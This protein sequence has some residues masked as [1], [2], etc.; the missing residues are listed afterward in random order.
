MKRTRFKSI[1][2][3]KVFFTIFIIISVVLNAGLFLLFKYQKNAFKYKLIRSERRLINS[4]SLNENYRSMILNNL[5]SESSP[6]NPDLVLTNVITNTKTSIREITKNSPILIL[7]FTEYSCH[8]CIE[9]SFMIIN[10]IPHL[11]RAEKFIIIVS[12]E[13]LRDLLLFKSDNN[14]NYSIYTMR[15]DS[16]T[17]PLESLNFPY[18]FILDTEN[19]A[20][21]IFYPLTSIPELTE[22]YFSIIRYKY[23]TIFK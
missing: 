3:T 11:F 14:I 19:K 23:P 2:N 16:L 20:S 18:F 17:V 15:N 7:R 6:V 1:V 21:N 22:D 10:N 8:A 9:Q 12:Y 13:S 5:S 4:E